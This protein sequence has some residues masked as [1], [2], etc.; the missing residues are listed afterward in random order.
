MVLLAGS[1][2]LCV[3][4]DPLWPRCYLCTLCSLPLDKSWSLPFVGTFPGSLPVLDSTLLFLGFCFAS[5][6]GLL[7]TLAVLDWCPGTRSEWYC[8]VSRMVDTQAGRGTPL[9]GRRQC[10]QRL[11]TLGES[12]LRSLSAP[13]APSGLP[14]PSLYRLEEMH[15]PAAVSCSGPCVWVLHGDTPPSHLKGQ[16][17]CSNS[18]AGALPS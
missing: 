14:V 13:R 18:S 6:G 5:P 1:L 15:T 2:T 10:H 11:W 3:S 12:R 17:L 7:A 16:P 9:R 8:R 4:S